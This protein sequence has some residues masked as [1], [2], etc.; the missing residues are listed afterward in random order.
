V[1][2]ILGALLSSSYSLVQLRR[3]CGPRPLVQCVLDSLGSGSGGGWG[4]I[5]HAEWR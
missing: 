5:R 3:N 4:R 1:F 2:A